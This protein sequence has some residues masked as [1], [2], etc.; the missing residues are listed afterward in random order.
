MTSEFIKKLSGDPIPAISVV[1]DKCCGCWACA[2][3]CPTYCLSMKEDGAGFKY[4]AY[5]SGC[6]GCGRCEKVCP[7][8]SV[9]AAD[10]AVSVSWAKAEDDG[11]RERSSS[12]GVFGLLSDKV[13][14]QDGVVYGAAYGKGCRSVGHVRI[15]SKEQLD[16]VMRS[17]YTQSAMG[18]DTYKDVAADLKAGKKVLFSG[19]GCQCAGLRNYLKLKRVSADNLL[20][21]EVLCHG[22]PSP[23]LWSEWLG[24][25]E[26]SFGSNA[27]E[28]DEVNFRSKSSGWTTYSVAYSVATEKVES[29]RFGEDWYMKAFLSNASLRESCLQCPAKRCSGSDVEIGDYWGVYNVHPDIADELGVSAVICNTEN[30][31]AAIDALGDALFFGPTTFQ[32]V[33]NGNPSLTKS[34]QPYAKRVEFLNDVSGSVPI[35]DLVRNWSFAPSFTQRVRGKL[36]R[37]KRKLIG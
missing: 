10:T 25:K 36:G 28:I 14:E 37:V 18:V 16:R 34:V 23:K 2:A 32:D 5:E 26:S 20:A 8:M 3:I 30:G 22:V 19:V 29:T 11:L 15:K 6:I 1:G 17:K 24:Y 31:K 4:P 12:G 9:G 21:V 33:A 35:E 13:L 7:V 27:A